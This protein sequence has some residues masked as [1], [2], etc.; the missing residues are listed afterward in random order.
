MDRG[1]VLARGRGL[2]LVWVQ[3][4]GAWWVQV[5]VLELCRGQVLARGRD[6]VL[7]RDCEWGAWWLL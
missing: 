6:L 3:E 5:W 2:V 7:A 4:W 1:C